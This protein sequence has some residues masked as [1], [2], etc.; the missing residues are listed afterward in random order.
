M[1]VL[2]A[3]VSDCGLAMTDPLTVQLATTSSTG[4]RTFSMAEAPNSSEATSAS[5]KGFGRD[6]MRDHHS[7]RKAGQDLAKKLNITPAPPA[8]DTLPAAGQRVADMLN[9]TPKGAS[10]DKT[11]IDGE[12][13]AHQAVAALLQAAQTAAQ[14]TSLKA[15]ITKAAPLIDAHLKKAQSI[16]SKVG[17][18]AAADSSRRARGSPPFSL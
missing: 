4:V 15:L 1:R 3:S 2:A 5:V 16:Q 13:A 8:G 11:Y 10:W 9:S 12:V 14:D 7:L 6:M 17:S 18:A